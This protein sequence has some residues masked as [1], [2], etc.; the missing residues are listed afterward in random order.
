MLQVEGSKEHKQ[1]KSS[2]YKPR[3]TSSGKRG[4]QNRK[5]QPAVKIVQGKTGKN[6]DGQHLSW[7][8][9]ERLKAH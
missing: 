8:T 6:S 7:D 2:G 4:C 1:N 3:H 9:A 5:A